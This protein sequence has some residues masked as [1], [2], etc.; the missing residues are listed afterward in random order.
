LETIKKGEEEM[1]MTELQKS[2]QLIS[3]E[4]ERDALLKSIAKTTVESEDE[5]LQASDWLVR[6]RGFLKTAEERRKALVGPL[7]DQVKAI[8]S[9]FSNAL[10]SAKEAETNLNRGISDF[11]LEQQRLQRLEQA[12]LD[13]LAEKR[14]DRAEAKG[15]V[16]PIP[17]I[18][19]PIAAQPEKTTVTEVG[20]VTMSQIWK[21]RLVDIN[22]VPREYFV[23]DEAKLTKV[24]RAGIRDIPGI[25]VYS[26][27]I[28]TVRR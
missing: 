10:I 8:N 4:G 23:L 20:K 18:I 24:V 21:W 3:L 25:Y 13:R 28:T 26:E 12:R 7:N 9:A 15:E 16:P 27:P 6:V 22:K 14:A 1:A 5:K 11:Y 17:E 2:E 19:A